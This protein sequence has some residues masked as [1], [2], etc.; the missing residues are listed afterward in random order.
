MLVAQRCGASTRSGQLSVVPP[1][2]ERA[3]AGATSALPGRVMLDAA[4]DLGRAAAGQGR[5]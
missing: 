2:I 5:W 4:A 1:L 3:T